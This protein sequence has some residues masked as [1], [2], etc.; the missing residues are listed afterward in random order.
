MVRKD[1]TE[2]RLDSTEVVR[3]GPDHRRVMAQIQAI[4]QALNSTLAVDEQ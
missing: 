4:E 3:S 2:L 1:G